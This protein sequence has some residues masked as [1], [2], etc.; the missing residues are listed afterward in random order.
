MNDTMTNFPNGITSFGIPVMGGG[1]IPA[2][3]GNYYQVN[4]NAL[5]GADG[6]PGT[7]AKPVADIQTAYGKVVSGQGDG[8]ILWA[9]GGDTSAD[10]TSYLTAQLVMDVFA[11]TVVGMGAPVP[12]AQR[13]RIANASGTALANLVDVQGD[14]NKFYNLHCFQG[15]STATSIGCWKVSGNRN[16]FNNCHFAGGGSATP[17]ATAGMYSLWVTGSE[18]CFDY[19]VI[20]LD[21]VTRANANSELLFGAGTGGQAARNRFRNCLFVSQS[22]TVGHGWVKIPASSIDRYTIFE[23]CIFLNYSVNHATTLTSGFL[24]TATG[25]DANVILKDCGQAGAAKWDSA[26][27]GLLWVMGAMT[28]VTAANAGLAVNPS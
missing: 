26:A 23:N 8:I 4:P 17:A 22:D 14:N 28:E 21:T 12:S 19:C 6:W 9:S 16:Y 7:K 24:N 18:N 3:F 20:G 2:I 10:T 15:D 27:T 11:L 5:Y 25:N 1:G 13:A